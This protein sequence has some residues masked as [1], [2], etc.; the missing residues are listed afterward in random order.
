MI[1]SALI[2]TITAA[3][4]DA[5]IIYGDVTGGAALSQ[6][7]IFQELFPPIGSVGNDIQ[8]SPNLFGFNEDQNIVIPVPLNVD[9]GPASTL[10]IG[11]EL[12][13]HYVFFDPGPDTALTGYVDFDANVL[14]IMTSTANLADSDFLA[15]VSANYL[16]PTL[17]GL[18]AGDIVTIDAANPMRINI[19]FFAG[20]P[21]DYIRVLT[22]RS[23][24]ATVPVP[25]PSTL[26]LLGAGLLGIFGMSRKCRNK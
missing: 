7:G 11:T 16:N 8:Q 6:G 10:A 20:T 12:A 5:I 2:F 26:Y 4:S 23:P 18:E 17:R 13:S 1:I 3:T 21:G 24:G 9:I 25:E 14:A 19:D 22:D 15:N